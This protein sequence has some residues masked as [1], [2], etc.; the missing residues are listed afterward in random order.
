MKR[1]TDEEI[2]LIE[3]EYAEFDGTYYDSD[4]DQISLHRLISTEPEWAE[5]R[6]MQ[7]TKQVIKLLQAVK[8]DRKQMSWMRS[9]KSAIARIRDEKATVARNR[10]TGLEANQCNEWHDRLCGAGLINYGE[11]PEEGIK[12]ILALGDQV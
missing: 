9:E 3:A 10:I 2:S 7:T 6:I 11:T 5:S 12:S 4:S 8:A 1:M